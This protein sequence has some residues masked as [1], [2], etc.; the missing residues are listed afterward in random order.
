MSYKLIENE[1]IDFIR[2]AATYAG[3]IT[4]VKRIVDLAGLHHVRT[5]FHG[6]P[7][8]SPICMAAHAHLNAWAPNFGIQEYLVLGTVECDALFPTEHK[9]EKGLMYVTLQALEL[10][11]MN[12][13]RVDI[14]T[15]LA[16]ILSFVC[17][18]EHSG[19]IEH[20]CTFVDLAQP[21]K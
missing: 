12:K 7:S 16:A 8:H 17:R 13:R 2:I 9:M 14:A 18:T 6:A 15:N 20:T 3:G 1:L 4:H 19:T 10:I 21:Q 5:G 11:L